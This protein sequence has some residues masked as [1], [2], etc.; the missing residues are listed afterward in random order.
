MREA[1]AKETAQGRIRCRVIVA[2]VVID[3][4]GDGDGYSDGE[5]QRSP[6]ILGK[7][8]GACRK[9]ELPSPKKPRFILL[10]CW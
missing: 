2:V 3:G 8:T 5:L 9:L 10:R 6:T 4:D 7:R 1:T